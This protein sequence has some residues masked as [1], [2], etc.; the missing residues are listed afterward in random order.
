MMSEINSF[1]LPLYF[2]TD[3]GYSFIKKRANYSRELTFGKINLLNKR[4]PYLVFYDENKWK[5]LSIFPIMPSVR[6]EIHF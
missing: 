5:E 6:W 4:N 1:S 3:I 2:R